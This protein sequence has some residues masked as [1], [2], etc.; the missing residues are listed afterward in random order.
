MKASIRHFSSR[1]LAVKFI[2]GPGRTS[3]ADVTLTRPGFAAFVSVSVSFTAW[4][5]GW[6][7]FDLP[8]WYPSGSIALPLSLAVSLAVFLL[9]TRRHRQ[10]STVDA[11]AALLG[12]PGRRQPGLLIGEFARLSWKHGPP[13]TDQ[14][15]YLAFT[16]SHAGRSKA[17]TI[18]VLCFE[19]TGITAADA[20]RWLTS[21]AEPTTDGPPLHYNDVYIAPPYD[22]SGIETALHHNPSATLNDAAPAR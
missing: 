9:T 8:T 19:G 4:L 6:F 2:Q 16:T 1:T 7:L 13:P 15:F 10:V 11:L 12:C 22:L 17:D 20:L 5:I 3:V 18:V 21:L 14:R